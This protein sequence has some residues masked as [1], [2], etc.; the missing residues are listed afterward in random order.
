MAVHNTFPTP[1]LIVSPLWD[2]KLVAVLAHKE[3]EI[4]ITIT[5]EYVLNATRIP[6]AAPSSKQY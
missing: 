2:A 5:D 3:S 1:A 6:I 4:G